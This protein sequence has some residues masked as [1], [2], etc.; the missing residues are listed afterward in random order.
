MGSETKNI[1]IIGMP[2]SGKTSL[3]KQ[4]S[5]N[6]GMK[7]VDMDSRI[8]EKYGQTIPEIFEA[9]GEV[10]FRK[11]ETAVLSEYA[12]QNYEEPILFSAGGGVITV[13]ENIAL[14]KKLGKII[15]IHRD[16]D[17]IAD[18]VRYNKDR[19]LLDERKK[20]YE[21]WEARKDLYYQAADAMLLNEGNFHETVRRLSR[22]IKET[23]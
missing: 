17:D 15:Y 7:F 19:P 23:V 14:L 9:E 1:V 20:L 12:E 8:V 11:K 2:G 4:A 13:I 5:K 6:C 18:S 16:V 10:G 3:G 22:L 21:L